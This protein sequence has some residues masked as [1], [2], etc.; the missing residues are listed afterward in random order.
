[1][2]TATTNRGVVRTVD[3]PWLDEG[4]LSAWIGLIKLSARIV[5][6]SDAALRRE[7]GI[8]GRDYELLHHVST[9]PQG[10]RLTDLAR[11]IDDSSSCITHRVNRLAEAGLIAKRPDPNDQRA[12]RIVLTEQ[13]HALLVRAA[14]DHVR[15]V[16]RWVIDPLDA[17]DLSTLARLTSVLNEHLRRIEPL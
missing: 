15:R 8:T 6:L 4:E 16:R 5:A 17:H 11:V 9:A 2:D 12:R 1:V 14:P 3:V 13:G 7:H 10:Q